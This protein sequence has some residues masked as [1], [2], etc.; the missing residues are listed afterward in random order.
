[1]SHVYRFYQRRRR[2]LGFALLMVMSTIVIVAA[3]VAEMTYQSSLVATAA[4]NSR[5]RMKAYQLAKGGVSLSLLRLKLDKAASD[6]NL[7]P[8]AD[9]KNEQ[10]WTYPL[11]FPPPKE[12]VMEQFKDR[13][14]SEATIK[15]RLRSFEI[16]GSIV[17]SIEDER[18]K[19]DLNALGLSPN[20]ARIREQLT[21]LFTGRKEFRDLFKRKK[22]RPGDLVINIIDY[23][24]ANNTMTDSSAPE[25][26]AYR[27]LDLNDN[28]E[29]AIKNKPM[30]TLE[31]LRLVP[32]MDDE[33]FATFS[34]FL[35]VYTY[36]PQGGN[37]NGQININTAD[38]EV[39][40][41]IWK[42][43]LDADRLSVTRQLLTLRDQMPFSSAQ[44]A[45]FTER[46]EKLGYKKADWHPVVTTESDT[47][48]IWSQSTVNDTVVTIE[49]VVRRST[50]FK[51][52][53]WRVL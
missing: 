37:S 18:A 31:E 32:G 1:M 50:L 48:K 10:L 2:Q 24:D 44:G 4:G 35:T 5:D 8:K 45:D 22:I 53:Y 36:D 46:M 39:L 41:T 17:A 11:L 30:D 51:L 49:A 19:I 15:E 27:E 52:L 25:E 21:N 43:D 23:V 3:I 26:N 9:H 33:L 7:L 20:R 34:P 28:K 13:A 40:R 47:F 16:E 42:G 14:V 12:F 6:F 29:F 38:P